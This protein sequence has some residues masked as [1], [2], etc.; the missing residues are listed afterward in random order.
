MTVSEMTSTAS[1][2][3]QLFMLSLASWS[4][5]TGALQGYVLLHRRLSPFTMRGLGLRYPLVLM[6]LAICHS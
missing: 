1:S 3:D 4:P 2:T 5:S 6:Q